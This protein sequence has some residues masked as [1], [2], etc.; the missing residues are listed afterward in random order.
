MTCID[1]GTVLYRQE[2]TLCEG[3]EYIRNDSPHQRL[4]EAMRIMA[5]LSTGEAEACWRGYQSGFEYVCEA[6]NH[7]GGATAVVNRAREYL[8]VSVDTGR[9]DLSLPPSIRYGR[10]EWCWFCGD[11]VSLREI[12]YRQAVFSWEW[13]AWAH[14]GCM[15]DKAMVD[16]TNGCTSEEA[17]ALLMIREF[18]EAGQEG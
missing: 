4:L 16:T 6:V 2:R 14:L 3:C 11:D 13:D 1:C 5:C 12:Y 8:A 15:L 18:T 17:E 9:V 10:T 7:Y